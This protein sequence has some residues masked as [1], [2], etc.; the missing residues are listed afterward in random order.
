[1]KNK[2]ITAALIGAIGFVGY[3]LYKRITK[4]KLGTPCNIDGTPSGIVVWRWDEKTGDKGLFCRRCNA[5][6]CASFKIKK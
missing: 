6:G 3:K 2:I 1:M 4:P 5:T